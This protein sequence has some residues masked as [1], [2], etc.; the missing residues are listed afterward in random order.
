MEHATDI[1]VEN[2]SRKLL[3][4]VAKPPAPVPVQPAPPLIL[5]APLPVEPIH[6]VEAL[7]FERV[8]PPHASNPI[9]VSR[10]GL[11]SRFALAMKHVSVMHDILLGDPIFDGV[12]RSDDI[13]IADNGVIM[14]ADDVQV[15]ADASG[16]T[17]LRSI[18]LRTLREIVAENDGDTSTG[19]IGTSGAGVAAT[20]V[21]VRHAQREGPGRHDVEVAIGAT[22]SQDAFSP[23]TVRRSSSMA[24][25]N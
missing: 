5:P 25:K 24:R 20:A 8:R 21:E 9:R 10:E 13:C 14:I 2:T 18:H 4:L 15:V 19:T 23:T 16:E 1:S 11:P 22:S 7:P 17:D 3:E 12:V 6:V